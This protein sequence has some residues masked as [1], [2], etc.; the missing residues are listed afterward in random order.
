[1]HQSSMHSNS[2][3]APTSAIPAHLS[4]QSIPQHRHHQSHPPPSP[5]QAHQH[6]KASKSVS[7][8]RTSA[9]QQSYSEKLKYLAK[10]QLT[11]KED[12]V[13]ESSQQSH[14]QSNDIKTSGHGNH[15]EN[16]HRSES[17]LRIDPSRQ[18]SS[19][20]SSNDTRNDLKKISSPQPPP[21]KVN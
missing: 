20:R 4:S 10:Q 21:E 17:D 18:S 9:E 5:Q 14:H 3:Y 16:T 6:Q 8:P 7:T 2:V 15:K 19:Y 11:G 12:D 13:K 1:M